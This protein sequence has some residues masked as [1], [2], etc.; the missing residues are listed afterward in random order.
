MSTLPHHSKNQKI[1]SGILR[2]Q[3]ED[4]VIGSEAQRENLPMARRDSDVHE[5]FTEDQCQNCNLKFQTKPAKSNHINI[6]RNK[7][8][9]VHVATH[10]FDK[11]KHMSIICPNSEC[12]LSFTVV[13][14]YYK[15]LE[16]AHNK[17]PT[18]TLPIY[19]DPNMDSTR[20]ELS[21]LLCRGEFTT[22]A[23]L[24]RH[25]KAC[26]GKQLFFCDLC[27]F[28]NSDYVK[29]IEH[30]KTHQT[31]NDFHVL[32]EFAKFEDEKKSMKTNQKAKI[33]LRNLGSIYKT[34]S[35][36]FNTEYTSM[37]EALTKENQSK[38]FKILKNV[39]AQ[40][41][42]FKFAL[43]TP[44]IISKTSEMG[45]EYRLRFFRTKAIKAGSKQ[46]IVSALRAA[47]NSLL[48]QSEHM[49]ETGSG[50]IVQHCR[51][52]DLIITGVN[53]VSIFFCHQKYA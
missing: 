52:L 4:M 49:E 48:L 53:G 45:N 47:V 31:D 38:L 28:S 24:T 29:V 15:H 16:N 12:C 19:Q 18:D 6:F 41:E 51:R 32:E 44:V 37:S 36:I 5:F 33:K 25:E 39:K 23:H 34:Y 14:E 8:N 22:K 21:C 11:N 3:T 50:W 1:D 17:L 27:T 46:A 43:C 40:K 42:E 2:E 30:G 20:N 35:K 7:R 10:I 26:T 9:I 13:G